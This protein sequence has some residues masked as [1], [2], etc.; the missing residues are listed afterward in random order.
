ML[1]P[2]IP[3]RGFLRLAV[4]PGKRCTKSVMIGEN[5]LLLQLDY[6]QLLYLSSFFEEVSIIKKG[7]KKLV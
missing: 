1:N 5:Q 6:P 2:A 4:L 3:W 7:L